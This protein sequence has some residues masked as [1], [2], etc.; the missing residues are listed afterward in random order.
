MKKIKHLIL[1]L[2]LSLIIVLTSIVTIVL[3][4][5]YKYPIGWVI[6]FLFLIY[7]IISIKEDWYKLNKIKELQK[8]FEESKK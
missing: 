7:A 8:Q 3:S 1:Q 4:L 6:G 2:Y 5:F